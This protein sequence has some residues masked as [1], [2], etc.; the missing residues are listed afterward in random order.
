MGKGV[1]Q[2]GEEILGGAAKF[3]GDGAFGG[4]GGRRIAWGGNFPGAIGRFE[5]AA[6]GSFAAE[7]A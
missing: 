5:R 1:Q 4:R 3:F 7:F 6:G 2:S